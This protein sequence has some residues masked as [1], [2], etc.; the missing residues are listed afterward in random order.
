MTARVLAMTRSSME[1]EVVDWRQMWRLIIC[2]YGIQYGCIS[3]T[4]GAG[5]EDDTRQGGCSPSVMSNHATR[6][7][8]VREQGREL[9]EDA[10][11]G[12]HDGVHSG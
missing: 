3:V 12:V 7:A 6:Q 10:H 11:H 8:R 9:S 1:E 5:R 2:T 4:V